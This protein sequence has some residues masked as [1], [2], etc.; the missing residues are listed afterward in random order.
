MADRDFTNINGIKVCDQTA[1]NSIPTKTSQLEND[2][3]YATIT[4]V[5]QAIDN[6]QIGGGSGTVDLSNYA[7]K[8]D[9]PTKTSQLTN[10]SGYI[11]NI[12]DE[13]I[14]ETELNAKGY[15]TTSQIPTVPTNVSAF[16][17]DANYASETFVTNK[18]AEA[19][20]GGG[21]GT[22]DLSG[23]VTKETGNASQ[24]T[25]ADGQTFQSKLD[26]GTLKGEK[27]DQGAQGPQGEIGPQ[28]P[29]G[30]NGADGLTTSIS[31]NG[32]TYTQVDG[33]VT[34]PDYP[35]GGTGA[36][37]VEPAESDLPKVFFNGSKPTTKDSVYATIEYISSTEH[38]KGYVDIKCQGSS[39]MSFPKKNFTI[40]MFTDDTMT[41]KLKKDFKGW[42]KQNKFCL[43]A[44]Y[45]D[46]SHARNVVSAKLWGEIVSS[47]SDYDTLPVELRTSPNNGAVDGFPIKLYYNGKYEGL[48]TWNIPKDKWTFNMDDTNTNHAVL[49]AEKNNG[50]NK[51]TTDAGILACE[52]RGPAVI[53]GTDWSL[54]VPDVLDPS[55][56][57][58]FNN[59]INC[60]KDTD[61]D[62]FKNT[63]GNY[64]DLTSAFDYF[65]FAYATSNVDGLAKNLIMITYDGVKWYCSAYDLDNV[66]GSKGSSP[67]V[68]E[69]VACPDDYY[70]N[71]S[72]LWERILTCFPKQLYDR[73]IE[74]RNSVLTYAN[75]INKF[76]RFTD[77]I[78]NDLYAEDV[79]I[80]T[81]IPYPNDNNIKQIRENARLRLAY[82][83]NKMAEL[84][85]DGSVSSIV[86]NGLDAVAE[87]AT[88]TLTATIIPSNA[89]NKEVEWTINNEYATISADG[90]TCTITGSA[91]GTSIITCTSKDTT[92]GTISAT[93]T[94]SITAASSGGVI[95]D[96]I[97]SKLTSKGMSS[98]AWVDDITSTS[99]TIVDNAKTVG[100]DYIIFNNNGYIN[101]GT[102]LDLT[103]DF[104]IMMKVG[105]ETLLNDYVKMFCNAT[106]DNKNLIAYGTA[107]HRKPFAQVKNSSGTTVLDHVE[108]TI[109]FD[110]NTDYVITLV[111]QGTTVTAY[112]NNTVLSTQT[113]ADI[114][115]NNDLYINKNGVNNNGMS[116]TL[117]YYCFLT[118]NRAL[119]AEEISTNIEELTK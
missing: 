5:N 1:R 119:T 93:K 101:Y 41:T 53:D 39:S 69:T 49:C 85:N 57:T 10:D 71:N 13:Y 31:V 81:G 102:T 108:N 112:L 68:N 30:Q 40:K 42:G 111:K 100:E 60:V 51:Q 92:N 82:M 83:D 90:L 4:Q 66:W 84:N 77:C 3:D 32:T 19:Q 117:R 7:K 72:L 14:T 45:I 61:N 56:R 67:F 18:I 43:K 79:E 97:V 58:S 28:G 23:Y 6:A 48:Y 25:F 26:A 46:H 34:L 38:F 95:T 55:I 11:T 35:S 47:R 75:V 114:S 115:V 62:T 2:S 103:G 80:Y 8:T 12:P 50:G 105:V 78:N 73:Y 20:L 52:F 76:E 9:L 36:T 89:L 113:G 110:N 88:I 59:L 106:S 37:K 24:I 96:G 65:L 118:Y 16:T 63:I 107:D 29:A 104:T 74:I 98:T 22:V 21:S 87:G 27:G 109:L 15:A 99:F 91:V 64:L 86:I 17:N 54:E 94:I 44:N 116:N 33:L 70:D